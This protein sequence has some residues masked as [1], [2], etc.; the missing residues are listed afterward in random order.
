MDLT[1]DNLLDMEPRKPT[2]PSTPTPTM[3]YSRQQQLAQE[4][5]HKISKF[6]DI[7]PNFQ[8]ELANRFNV[9]SQEMAENLT[10]ASASTTIQNTVNAPLPNENTLNAPTLTK[11]L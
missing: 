11:T 9:L 3:I 5:D 1:F 10:T 6:N 2:R 8:I 4:V 7:Q